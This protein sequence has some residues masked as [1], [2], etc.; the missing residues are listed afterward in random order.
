M[1]TA[2]CAGC[3]S[4][5]RFSH[6]R[7]GQAFPP[8]QPRGF[9]SRTSG[10]THYKQ[11]TPPRSGRRRVLLASA[12]PLTPGALVLLSEYDSNDG[13]TGEKH[14]LDASREE[15]DSSLPSMISKSSHVRRA[16]YCF[17]D[18][19]LW[20]PLCTGF[21]FLHLVIIFVPVISTAPAIWFG[22]RVSKQ[23]DERAGA[24]WWYG[25]LVR[26]MERGGP[27]FIKVRK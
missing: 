2:F 20:E 18:T 1:R 25:F 12:A 17:V 19:Y 26:S 15:I 5:L 4:W 8:Q 23:D 13:E 16:I 27:A 14:M 24:L 10:W 22:G 7:L 6:R 9:S 11:T 21:R 3:R